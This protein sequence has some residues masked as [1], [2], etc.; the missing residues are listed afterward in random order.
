MAHAAQPGSAVARTASPAPESQ[1]T[2]PERVVAAVER[3]W[4][5]ALAALLLLDLV[6]LLYMGRGLT[7]FYDEWDFVQH[8]FGGG[9]HSLLAAHV[10]NIS[11]F[12]VIVYKILF[13]LVGLNHYAVYRLVVIVLHLVSGGLIF[14]LAARRIPRAP[15]LLAA[16]LILFLGAAWE[17]LLWAFQVG[18][19]LSAAG[20][21]AVWVL[22]ERDDRFGDIAAL[23]CLIVSVGSSSLGIAIMI[24]VAVELAWKRDWRRGWIVVIPAILYAL[25]YLKYGESQITKDGLI[26]APGFVEDLA[27][28]AFAGL[29]GRSLEWG[30][31]LAVLGIVVVVRR[32]VRPIPVSARLAGLVATGVALWMITAAARSTVSPP[33]TSRYIYLGAIVIVLVGVELLREI[34]ITPRA[35]AVASALVAF[36][37]V[38]GLTVMHAGALG[39]RETSKTLTAELGALELASTYAPQSYHPDPQRAPTL[40]AGPYLHTVRAIGSSPADTPAALAAA[41]PRS[42]AAAD[43][44]LVALGAPR[45]T[46][47]GSTRPSPLAPAPAVSALVSGTQVQHGRCLYLTPL[48]GTVMSAILIPP[49]GGVSISDRG[50]T[51][52]SLAYRRFGEPFDPSPAVVTPHSVARLSFVRDSATV[53][54]QLQAASHSALA[55][56]GLAP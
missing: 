2:R 54:W 39:L 6:V 5:Y 53:P 56:C 27:A 44:V 19:L 42:R 32:L 11:L 52:A 3:R 43:A 34:S 20:G 12:P 38:T 46:P 4:P 36:F 8:D 13:H 16:A 51:P 55:V 49:E 25:W 35:T 50:D 17:D 18:Y 23:L 9:V 15:A 21:L 1:G 28:A 10:G 33:E 47:L 24:G 37:A 26:N 45:L 31:P 40:E 14:V 22:L 30:R 7:F 29:I 41:D 48:P